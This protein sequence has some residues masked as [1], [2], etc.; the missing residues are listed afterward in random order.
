MG[1]T[2]ENLPEPHGLLRAFNAVCRISAPSLLFRSEAIVQ[3][4]V[5]RPLHRPD[6]VS[7]YLES[8]AD[9]FDLG[10]SGDVGL[11]SQALERR[12]NIATGHS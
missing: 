6:G 1:T 10:S 7:I 3:S 4:R 12:H 11:L 5:R 9:G 8:A 2:Y